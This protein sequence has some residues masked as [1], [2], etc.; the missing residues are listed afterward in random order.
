LKS[1]AKIGIFLLS[2]IVSLQKKCKNDNFYYSE[3]SA[4]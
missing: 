4:S 1:V 3:L 2:C